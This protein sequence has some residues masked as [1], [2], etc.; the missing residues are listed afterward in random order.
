M[1]FV[2]VVVVV[3]AVAVEWIME[4]RTRPTWIASMLSDAH[5]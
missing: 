2:A 1:S 3:V 4:E 5:A